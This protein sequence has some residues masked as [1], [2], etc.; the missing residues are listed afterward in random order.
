MIA[1]QDAHSTVLGLD[2][3]TAFFGVYDGHGGKEVRANPAPVAPKAES[4]LTTFC[5]LF[6]TNQPYRVFD[7]R[8][9]TPSKLPAETRSRWP[10]TYPGI[11][12]RCSRSASRTSAATSPKV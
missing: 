1:S 6:S 7:N 9:V 11:F 2:D 10:C 5:H 4:N 8:L 12:T 3:D